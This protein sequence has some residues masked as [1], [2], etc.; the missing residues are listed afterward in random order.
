MRCHVLIQNGLAK[1]LQK[2]Q[3][4]GLLKRSILRGQLLD[5]LRDLEKK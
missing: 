1:D 4:R 3:G 5:M 2:G